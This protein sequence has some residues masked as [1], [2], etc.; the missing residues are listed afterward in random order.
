MKPYEEAKD[1]F[2]GVVT[3]VLTPFKPNFD[4][5]YE[6]LAEHVEWLVHKGIKTG[7]GALIVTG[8]CG[9]GPFLTVEETKQITKTAVDA[10]GSRVPVFVGVHGRMATR[11]AVDLLKYAE[12]AGAMGAQVAPPYYFAPNREELF[13]YFKTVNDA[14]ELGLEIYNTWWLGATDIDPV[15]F[16]KKLLGLRHIIAMKW[17]SKSNTNMMNM[18]RLFADRINFIDN[19]IPGTGPLVPMLGG[20]GFISIIANHNPELEI[21]IW[22][23]LQRKQYKNA[24]HEVLNFHTPLYAWKAE[25]EQAMMGEAE[26][27]KTGMEIIGR[28]LGGVRPP[29]LPLNRGQKAKVREIMSSAGLVGV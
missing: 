5:N 1:K 21:K 12:S 11:E 20:R 22:S 8:T 15:F 6:K 18:M 14:T 29:Q 9:E 13:T 10:V 23:L 27:F 3:V 24:L 2:R 26:P 17:S 25:P 4:V 7:T 19:D 28:P 16:E